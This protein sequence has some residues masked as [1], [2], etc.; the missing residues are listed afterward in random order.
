M[1]HDLRPS[2]PLSS[3]LGV[4]T[5]TYHTSGTASAQVRISRDL[6]EMKI[7]GIISAVVSFLT[8]PIA[9]DLPDSWPIEATKWSSLVDEYLPHVIKQRQDAFWRTIIANRNHFCA[10]VQEEV[11]G[12]A[13]RQWISA[14]LLDDYVAQKPYNDALWNF[15]ISVESAL[16]GRK[17]F[18]TK[19]SM[20]LAPRDAE[21]GDLVC[22][23]LG[24]EVPMMLRRSGK[25]YVLI[26][27][28]YYHGIMEGEALQGLSEHTAA[29]ETF[30]IV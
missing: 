20:G 18:I 1:D 24:C 3:Q 14:N 12:T 5:K 15:A 25:S 28:C 23:L 4:K 21:P 11:E 17:F 7:Q 13:F 9:K 19:E 27:E 30:T 22:V 26:G 6:K 8:P 2:S 29:L 10:P 16:N